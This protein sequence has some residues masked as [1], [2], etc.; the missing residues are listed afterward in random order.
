VQAALD[1]A[2]RAGARV[3][4]RAALDGGAPVGAPMANVSYIYDTL[5]IG[6]AGELSADGVTYFSSLGAIVTIDAPVRSVT[7]PQPCFLA[8][9]LAPAAPPRRV[10]LTQRNLSTHALTPLRARLSA[11]RRALL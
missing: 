10:R 11:W 8:H 5:L 9:S 4:A 1:G 6:F 2:A 3:S 7:R